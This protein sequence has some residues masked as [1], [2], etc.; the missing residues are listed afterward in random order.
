M[1]AGSRD[2]IHGFSGL[3]MAINYMPANFLPLLWMLVL[4]GLMWHRGG[5]VPE[6]AAV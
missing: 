3:A 6:E 4:G 1:Q 2:R 5:A